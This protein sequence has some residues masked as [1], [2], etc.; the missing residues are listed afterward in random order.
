MLPHACAGEG[1]FV[2]GSL[3]SVQVLAPPGPAAEAAALAGQQA[4]NSVALAYPFSTVRMQPR[5]CDMHACRP[6][7]MFNPHEC[8][9]RQ[10]LQRSCRKLGACE[11]AQSKQGR[12]L[13]SPH[14]PAHSCSVI[15]LLHLLSGSTNH[16]HVLPLGRLHLQPRDVPAVGQASYPAA[17]VSHT[18]RSPTDSLFPWQVPISELVAAANNPLTAAPGPL[19][20]AIQNG[21]AVVSFPPA[22]ERGAA[23]TSFVYPPVAEVCACVIV[24]VA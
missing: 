19:Q 12:K 2:L 3:T 21:A 6:N 13:L 4:V 18:N 5:I 16:S 17:F 1:S 11:W 14:S 24:W 9:L 15:D 10:P 23:T 7:P 8:S 20:E 22:S